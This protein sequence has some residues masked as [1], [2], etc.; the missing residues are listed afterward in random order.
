M[1]EAEIEVMFDMEKLKKA[2]EAGYGNMPVVW[3][4]KLY[5]GRN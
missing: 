4:L 3:A 1:P 5:W 2:V